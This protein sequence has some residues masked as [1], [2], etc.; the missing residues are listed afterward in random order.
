MKKLFKYIIAVVTAV[1]ISSSYAQAT[2]S[3]KGYLT[4]AVTSPCWD[5]FFP[6]SIFSYTVVEHDDTDIVLPAEGDLAGI[7]CSCEEATPPYFRIGMPLGFFE[8]VGLAEVVREPYCFEAIGTSLSDG[9]IPGTNDIHGEPDIANAFYNVHYYKFPLFYILEL[10]T[11]F[12]CMDTS[13]IDVA[14]MTEVD[15]TWNDDVLAAFEFPEAALF[16]DSIVQAACVADCLAASTIGPIDSMF[17]CAGCWGSMYPFTGTVTSVGQGDVGVSA[18]EITRMYAKLFRYGLEWWTSM[19]Y[20]LCTS[21][22]TGV[23]VKSQYK[24]TQIGPLPQY[25]EPCC[26]AT[27]RS[28][29]IWGLAK[30]YPTGENFVYVMWRLRRCCLL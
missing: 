20:D 10:L 25:T 18:L 29:S 17:W 28:P 16:S 2:C 24:F 26:H 23:I 27:G 1:L 19:Q 6:L 21:I 14:Y 3:T 15:P 11:D 4:D 13:S 7:L 9:E 12:G 5:C 30:S 8:P 22:P